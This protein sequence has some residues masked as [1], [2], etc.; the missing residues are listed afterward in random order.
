MKEEAINILMSKVTS[1]TDF[2][3]VA[4]IGD[5]G[6]DIIPMYDY[7]VLIEVPK[8]I[9]LH[10]VKSRSCEKF[11]E[12]MSIGGDLYGSENAFFDFVNKRPYNYV[13]DWINTLTCPI[14]KVD[15]TK[16]IEE[17]VKHI[18]EQMQG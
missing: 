6:G 15:G 14:I 8:D 9:R 1:N 12:R 2:I 7:A 13:E 3:F 4:V 10:R 11:G 18:I 17:N 5:Y 16:P